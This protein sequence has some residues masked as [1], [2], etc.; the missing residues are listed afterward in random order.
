M[1]RPELRRPIPFLRGLVSLL[2]FVIACRSGSSSSGQ[3]ASPHDGS[4]GGH[5]ASVSSGTGGSGGAAG[6][7]T[8]NTRDAGGMVGPGRDDAPIPPD[9]VVMVQ[10]GVLRLE[11][12]G[13]SI[14]RVLYGAT[15]PMPAPSLAVTEMRPKTHF[16]VDDTA[17]TLTITTSKLMAEV[18]KASG[19]VTFKTLGETV[20]LATAATTPHQLTPNHH[21]AGMYQ[22]QET[23]APQ[24]GERFYG[25]GQHQQ[26]Q[27]GKMAYSGSLQLLQKNPGESSVPV[28][29][30]SAGYGIL[31]DNPSVTKVDLDG[32]LTLSSEVGTLIDYYFISG[33]ADEAVAGYRALTGA[34]PMFGKWAFGYWQSKDRYDSQEELL[35]V[36]ATYRQKEVPID[37]I[38]QDWHYWGGSPWGSHL[39][40]QSYP[41]P[42]GMFKTLHDMGF[43]A[44]VSVWG[45]FEGGSANYEALQ[46]AGN[47]L[48]PALWGGTTHYYDPFKG[49]GRSMYWEQMNADLFSKGVDGWWLDAT[50]PELNGQWG[51][52]RDFQTGAGTGAGVANAY[53]LMTTTAVHDGQRGTTSDKRVFI[54]TRSAYAGQQRNGAATWSGDITGD[55]E[56]FKRQIP[57]GLNFSLSG[58]PYWTTDTGG[59]RLGSL[60]GVGS[61]RYTELFERWFQFSAFCPIFRTHGTGSDRNLYAFGADAEKVLVGVDKLRYRLLP[62]IYSLAWMVTRHSYTPMRALLF[63]FPNDPMATNIPDQFMY[64][65][66]LLVNPVT[67]AGVSTR[68]VY[69]PAANTWYDFWTGVPTRGGQTITASAPIS[70]LPVYVRAGSI[71]PLGPTVQYA[72]EKPV[73]PIELRVYRGADASFTLYEDENDNYGYE[74]GRYATIPITFSEAHQRLT[75]GARSGSFPGML[76]SRMFR[77][78]LVR[79]GHGIG[80]AEAPTADQIVT[81]NGAAVDVTM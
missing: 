14:V 71:V 54:L 60:G 59:Y 15:A 22:T 61:A 31:W 45:K 78:V 24:H 30:S 44:M 28:L 26:S 49:A 46:A 63:D 69:L 34:A 52:F 62:Y 10:G 48:T 21:G 40:S 8:V 27:G 25:L 76:R 5:D 81:Y 19:R 75:I 51:E 17:A 77:V 6:G 18:D 36:A 43:H 47:L 16:Q 29:I 74:K 37:N 67:D 32:A 66:A 55:W 41:D 73:D 20:L 4:T 57:A 9:P 1:P 53:P 2:T 80:A 39:F 50:E 38:V 23:F 65:P 13:E 11:V 3:A 72:T 7:G 68:K 70:H 56:T 35:G 58:I 12:W 42:A 33:G 64:G 79:E